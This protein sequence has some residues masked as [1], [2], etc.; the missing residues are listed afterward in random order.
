MKRKGIIFIISSP[1]GGGK[2][3]ICR[4][5]LKQ[6]PE[7]GYSISMTSRSPRLGEKEGKDY[8]FISKEEFDEKISKGEFVEWAQVHGYHYGTPRPFLEEVLRSD[9]DIILDI[10]V[11]GALQ[12][13]KEYK[14]SCL[15]FLLP[16]SLETLASRLR[17]RKTDD[18]KEIEKRLGKAQ[19]EITFLK[20]YDYAIV[21]QELSQAVEEAKAIIIAE[22]CRMPANPAIAFC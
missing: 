17:K 18:K 2:T 19:E 21:N 12:I 20:E 8:F 10:D 9:R 6:L 11:Q 5:L 14:T 7:L 22:R 16:P 15:I 4:E 13:K 3:T 1:S